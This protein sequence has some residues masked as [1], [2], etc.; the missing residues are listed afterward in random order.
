[1]TREL[2]DFE[3]DFPHLHRMWMILV[4][5]YGGDP[6]TPLTG[7]PLRTR[8]VLIAADLEMSRWTMGR[9]I[10]WLEGEDEDPISLDLEAVLDDLWEEASN[11]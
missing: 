8:K 7:L 11:V 6:R 5:T 4:E 9:V 10:N 1:M 2:T 3:C